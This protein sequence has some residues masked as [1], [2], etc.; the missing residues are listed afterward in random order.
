MHTYDT[1]AR[2]RETTQ[3]LLDLYEVEEEYYIHPLKVWQRYSPTMFLPHKIT[4]TGCVSITSSAE[5]AE[6]LSNMVFGSERMDYWN[7]TV[8]RARETLAGGD[9]QEKEEAKRLL[10]ALLIGSDSR[11]FSYVPA[12][13]SPGGSAEDCVQGDWLRVYRRQ[14]RRYASGQADIDQGAGKQ[15][16]FSAASGGP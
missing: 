2:I 13:F 1:I 4:E 15:R 3:I 9:T 7:M 11:M 8:S 5:T 12:V 6:L 14:E 10:A 16:V